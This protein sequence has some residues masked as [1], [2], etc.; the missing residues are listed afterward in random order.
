MRSR[1]RRRRAS[2]RRA[3]RT[4]WPGGPRSSSRTGTARR[5]S[6]RFLRPAAT[7][8]AISRSRPLSAPRPCPARS[9]AGVRR[10]PAEPSQLSRRLVAQAVRS[11]RGQLGLCARERA[12]APLAITVAAQRRPASTRERAAWIVAPTASARAA[13]RFASSAAAASCPSSS[14]EPA[15]ARAARRPPRAAARRRAATLGP[16]DPCVGA[17]AASARELRPRERGLQPRTPAGLD[18]RELGRAGDMRLLEASLGPARLEE[19]HRGMGV[20]AQRDDAVVEARDQR[21]SLLRGRVGAL[22]VSGHRRDPAL[23][24]QRPRRQLAVA[25]E[26]RGLDGA[27]GGVE[28]LRQPAA[29]LERVRQPDHHRHDELALPGGARD[30]DA[31]AQVADRLVV[32]LAE[33]LGE[34]EVVGGLEPARQR[35]VGQRVEGRG[36]LRARRLGG[37]DVALRVAREAQQRGR[38]HGRE[39]RGRRARRAAVRS[40]ARPRRPSRRSRCRTARRRRARPASAPAAAPSASG[41][42]SSTRSS[43]SWA[44]RCRPSRFSHPRTRTRAARAARRS[45]H[46][47]S[48]SVSS[49]VASARS[50]CPVAASDVASGTSSPQSA[51]GVVSRSGIS[52]SA[53]PNQRTAPAGARGAA[54]WPAAASSAIDASSPISAQRSTWWA[55]AASDPPRARELRAPRARG[56]AVAIPRPPPRTPSGARSG[57]GSGSDAPR[58][59]RAAARPPRVSSSAASAAG[60]GPI[61]RRPRR[62]RAARG[63]R[64]PPRPRRAAARARSARRSRASSAAATAAG[65][66]RSSAAP[67][68]AAAARAGELQQ[69]ERVAAGEPVQLARPARGGLAEQLA[70]LASGAARAGGRRAGRRDRPPA[71][72]PR[73]RAA[74][75]RTRKPRPRSR[76]LAAAAA[77]GARAARA[78][79]RPPSAVVEQRRRAARWSRDAPASDAHGAMR[80]EALV[81][82]R[83]RAPPPVPRRAGRAPAR[84]APVAEHAARRRSGPSQATWSSSASTHTPNGR[85]RSSSLPRPA[86]TTCA[87]GLAAPCELLEQARL[88]DARLVRS[89]RRTRA[90]GDRADEPPSP[91]RRARGGGRRS[92]PRRRSPCQL[93]PGAP[94]RSFCRL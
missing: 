13:A 16:L 39:R 84:A 78:M 77:A 83:R 48:A 60:S 92:L 79:R 68:A 70:G 25:R 18:A 69:I 10:V 55:R 50:S 26:P 23:G 76:A 27:L 35:R 74:G 4:R 90:S 19:D 80:L 49:S 65:P 85:S 73:P 75:G 33:E 3:S 12:R 64:R 61:R 28:R 63:R 32:V 66:A 81:G 91:A 94:L 72:P 29:D 5:R 71:A 86:S 37:V 56:A 38:G 6:A 24:H 30:R 11:A 43:R 47:T 14:A 46:G 45:R 62:A 87:G 21:D 1:P 82:Q 15:P 34:A 44:A 54:S 22:E 57:A 20:R 31:A 58:R 40:H 53:A 93:P 88:A 52:R 36:G 8:S 7:R 9:A 41:S 89:P 42:S 51:L 59:S 67:A 2:R 17:L